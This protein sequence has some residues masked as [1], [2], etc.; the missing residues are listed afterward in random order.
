MT[1]P[2]PRIEMTVQA[3]LT[4]DENGK[5]VEGLVTFHTVPA[6]GFVSYLLNN[7]I[8][9]PKVNCNRKGDGCTTPITELQQHN[10]HVPTFSNGAGYTE[11][12]M[13]DYALRIVRDTHTV[14]KN[15]GVEVKVKQVEQAT[16]LV[17]VLKEYVKENGDGTG[18]DV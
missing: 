15:I 17:N 7:K 6:N 14:C 9:I 13:M 2:V 3:I 1:T 11:Q 18:K 16:E 12:D 10:G 8:E 4:R 5:L